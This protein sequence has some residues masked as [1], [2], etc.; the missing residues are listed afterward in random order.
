MFLAAAAAAFLFY[1][2]RKAAGL[3]LLP[4]LAWLCFAASLNYEIKALNPGAELAAP[5]GGTDIPL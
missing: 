5:A 1:R 2:I 3:L 4:Y